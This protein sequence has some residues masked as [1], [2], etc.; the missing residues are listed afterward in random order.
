VNSTVCL[1]KGNPNGLMIRNVNLQ[2]TSTDLSKLDDRPK[3]EAWAQMRLK[4]VAAPVV[5]ANTKDQVAVLSGDRGDS[6][7]ETVPDCDTDVI[8]ATKRG[9]CNE[10]A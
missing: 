7:K 6:S 4:C 5:Q 3:K 2:A 8:V 1:A 10:R 9:R